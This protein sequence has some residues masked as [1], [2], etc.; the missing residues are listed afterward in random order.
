MVLG[1]EYSSGY[2]LLGNSHGVRIMILFGLAV[3]FGGLFPS[4]FIYTIRRAYQRS[5]RA[6]EATFAWCDADVAF[7][8]WRLANPDQYV[9]D[10]PHVRSLVEECIQTYLRFLE[11]H[12]FDP[13]DPGHAEYLT[14]LR[15]FLERTRSY[16]TP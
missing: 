7:F 5:R 6:M 13:E 9:G 12:G 3:L 4:W 2:I 10:T 8:Q 16:A 11:T 15:S 14:K 1:V